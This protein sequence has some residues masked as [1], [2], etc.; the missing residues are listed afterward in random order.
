MELTAHQTD[1]LSE[2]INIGYARAA[3]ALSELTGYRIMLEVP[4]VE[5]HSIKEVTQILAQSIKGEVASVHQ[6]FSGPVGGNAL[7]LL[8][9]EAAVML[10]HLLT[11]DSPAN[12]Q[13]DASA[14]EVLTEV[15]NIVLNACLGVFG[16]LLQVQVAFAVP[17]LHID[18]VEC[19]LNS[20]T[21]DQKELQYALMIQT[22][23]NLRNSNVKGYLVII[24][25]ITSLDTLLHELDEWEKRQSE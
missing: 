8:D 2:L 3:G 12:K 9:H 16:N 14:R 13:L 11:N 23:F 1:S 4:R 18:A 19:V 7:L 22:R 20:I 25:G 6:V 5:A 15:G 21:V 24:L 17:R 10:N